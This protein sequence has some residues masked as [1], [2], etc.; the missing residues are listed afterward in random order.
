ML[1]KLILSS[2]KF[3]RLLSLCLVAALC[4]VLAPLMLL[5]S[6]RFGIISSLETNLKSNPSNLEIRMMSG[7]RLTEDFFDELK[8]N[9]HIAFVLPLTRSLSVTANIGFNKKVMSSVEAIPTAKGDPIA[10]LSGLDGVLGPQDAYLNETAASDLGIKTGDTFKFVVSRIRE[11]RQVNAVVPMVL[12]GII[13]KEYAAHKSVYINF[14]TLVYMEDYKDG[15]E[16]LIFSDGSEPNE[17]R[18]TFAKARIYVKTLEDVAPVSELLRKKY[19]IYDKLSSIE[20]LKAISRVLS[21][22]FMT[23]AATSVVGGI[24]AIAGLIMT[25]VLRLEKTF[26]LLYLTGLDRKDVLMLVVGQNI[27]LAALA[28][29]LSL[30]LFYAG[31]FTFNMYFKDLLGSGTLVSVLNL[32]H[33]LTGLVL[34]LAGCAA[35]S[36]IVAKY[37]V[38][39]LKVAQSL[40]QV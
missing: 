28:Y 36:A 38:L 25:N 29:A 31:M 32:S 39:K 27:I 13:K 20:E 8:A 18:T 17:M 21:F 4:S 3:D 22:I 10:K 16:P 7:Y 1:L 15:F 19:T 6:L 40:R 23:V 24:L 9:P 26:A 34:T 37:T 11:G 2:L 30:G 5:F 35:V 14:D 12:K 33:I